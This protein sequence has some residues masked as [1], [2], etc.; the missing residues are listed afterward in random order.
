MTY[1]LFSF[2]LTLAPSVN[3]TVDTFSD[4]RGRLTGCILSFY[5]NN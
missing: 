1:H 2:L 3:L 4:K 5:D